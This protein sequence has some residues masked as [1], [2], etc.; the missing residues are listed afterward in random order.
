VLTGVTG[1]AATSPGA[2]LTVANLSTIGQGAVSGGHIYTDDVD[3]QGAAVDF[4]KI[5]V[6]AT[7]YPLITNP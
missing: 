1:I 2:A 7:Q 4:L 6:N 5:T 3:V